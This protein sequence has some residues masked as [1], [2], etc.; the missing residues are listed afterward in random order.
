MARTEFELDWN[1]KSIKIKYIDW[2][3][4]KSTCSCY[5]FSVRLFK[6]TCIIRSIIIIVCIIIIVHTNPKNPNSVLFTLSFISF[7]LRKIHMK[8]LCLN[9]LLY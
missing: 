6:H 4:R 5:W 2:E 7:G 1:E 9:C 3:L 8:I